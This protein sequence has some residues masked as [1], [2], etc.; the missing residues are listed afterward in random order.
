MTMNGN[1]VVNMHMMMMMMT[2]TTTTTTTTSTM[3]DFL[4]VMD[5]DDGDVCT[6]MMLLLLLTEVGVEPVEVNSPMYQGLS[7]R[8]WLPTPPC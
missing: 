2:T 7:L 1:L 3:S 5:I 8:S 6:L 4:N